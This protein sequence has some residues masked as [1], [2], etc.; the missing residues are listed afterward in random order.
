MIAEGRLRIASVIPRVRC[1]GS[2]VF[3]FEPS[4]PVSRYGVWRRLTCRGEAAWRVWP[5]LPGRGRRRDSR[6]DLTL[7]TASGPWPSER[8]SG[9][10]RGSFFR[11]RRL[12]TAPLLSRASQPQRLECFC[13]LE[14]HRTN[15]NSKN[16]RLAVVARQADAVGRAGTSKAQRIRPRST[17]SPPPKPTRRRPT[18]PLSIPRQIARFRKLESTHRTSS[19]SSASCVTPRVDGQLIRRRREPLPAG[20]RRR[21]AHHQRPTMRR[22]MRPKRSHVHRRRPPNA[23]SASP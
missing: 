21:S 15:R 2:F 12:A 14:P 5:P 22:G 23:P 11:S 8:R 20:R 16:L 1:A 18:S 3:R 17:C 13:F 6:G 4:D 9:C 10:P 7:G 19:S